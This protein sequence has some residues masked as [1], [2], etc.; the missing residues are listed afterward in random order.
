MPERLGGP[1][2]WSRIT[3]HGTLKV[4]KS[5][6]AR[7]VDVSA[8]HN[9]VL[10]GPARS[11]QSRHFNGELQKEEIELPGDRDVAPN[12]NIFVNG[13]RS[14]SCS[15]CVERR[16]FDRCSGC[17][18]LPRQTDRQPVRGN[19]L[20]LSNEPRHQSEMLDY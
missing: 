7:V 17:R 13:R 9:Q 3:Y 1:A 20:V 19:P 10:F 8:K 5:L 11:F 4:K 16:V 6:P 2:G 15:S 12:D 18:E 14:V